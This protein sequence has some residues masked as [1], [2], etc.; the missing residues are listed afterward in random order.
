MRYKCPELF[1]N[2]TI[3]H[4]AIIP[5]YK[6]DTVFSFPVGY[7]LQMPYYTPL[8]FPVTGTRLTGNIL[9]DT[10]CV[11]TNLRI[12]A[13]TIAVEIIVEK[14][15]PCTRKH[16]P[17]NYAERQRKTKQSYY[18]AGMITMIVGCILFRVILIFFK[19]KLNN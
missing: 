14:I 1:A 19:T 2:D 13:D 4:I 3:T 8:I 12:P 16:L 10:A 11:R 6:Y 7:R 17:E 9:L 5:E 18:I 15:M